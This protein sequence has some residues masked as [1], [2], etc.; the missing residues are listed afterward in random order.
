[1]RSNRADLEVGENAAGVL[2]DGK[3]RGT[4][5]VRSFFSSDKHEAEP[6]TSCV[7]FQ[8]QPERPAL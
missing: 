4:P 8:G 1:M 7:T 2:Q 5:R 3:R 6:S